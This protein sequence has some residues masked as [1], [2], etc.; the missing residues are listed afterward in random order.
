MRRTIKI[1]L[2]IPKTIYFNFRYLPIRRALKLPIWLAPNVRVKNMYKGG[3]DGDL[4]KIGMIH[5]G[6]HEADAVDVYSAHTI[7]DVHK[8]CKL[9][10]DGDA[11][12]GHGAL[13]CVKE[14]GSLKLGKHFAISGTTKIV[15]SKNIEIGN[16]VQF[17]WDTL[18]MDSDA[19][20]IIGTNG[21]PMENT[22]PIKIGNHVWIA[23]NCMILKGA[24]IS[25]N[26]VVGACSLVTKGK[27]SENQIIVGSPAKC[28][29]SIDGWVL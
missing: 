22:S 28:I 18:V 20:H 1:L 7:L 24:V 12:I 4:N 26:C 19:H 14:E 5:I 25:D 17:S 8:G 29:K 15:C 16:D 21:V 9:V 10:F 13:L 6:Y 3:I 11:H 23:A 2:S 27:F